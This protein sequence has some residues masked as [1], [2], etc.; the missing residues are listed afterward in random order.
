MRLFPIILLAMLALPACFPKSALPPGP[1]SP[2]VVVREQAR[3][4]AVTAE[5]LEEGRQV[6]IATCGQCH[7][8]PDIHAVA[9]DKWPRILD[10]MVA[11][12]KLDASATPKLQEFV[13]AA[14]E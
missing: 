1:L 14:H 4:P 5:S 13:E 6:F 10:R 8:H 2:E 9:L 7:D 11:R 12:T 3:R